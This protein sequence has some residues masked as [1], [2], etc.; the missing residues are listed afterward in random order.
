MVGSMLFK[1]ILFETGLF[2]TK[3]K[4]VNLLSDT[5]T[6]LYVGLEEDIIPWLF[7]FWRC[8]VVPQGLYAER[9]YKDFRR[10][11]LIESRKLEKRTWF[12][13][14]KERGLTTFGWKANKVKAIRCH[15]Y[16]H[17]KETADK[18]ELS[19]SDEDEVGSDDEVSESKEDE[20]ANDFV[21]VDSVEQSCPSRQFS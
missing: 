5:S 15:Y 21:F 19:A 17:Y 9:A 7:K 18:D 11:T 16:W 14:K 4:F 6:Y 12:V 13:S 10:D 1:E 2:T 20:R 3:C 8:R